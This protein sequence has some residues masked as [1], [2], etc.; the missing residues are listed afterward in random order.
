[1]IPTYA[2]GTEVSE[3]IST[4]LLQAAIA[5]TPKATIVYFHRKALKKPVYIKLKD[6]FEKQGLT[7]VRTGDL[8]DID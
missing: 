3:M 1:M 7:A 4:K 2:I 6:W 5:K 8:E